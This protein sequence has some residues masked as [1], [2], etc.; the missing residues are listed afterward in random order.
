M[1]TPVVA[2]GLFLLT[3][4]SGVTQVQAQVFFLQGQDGQCSNTITGDLSVSGSVN[5]NAASIGVLT[6]T[7]TATLPNCPSGYTQDTQTTDFVLCTNSRGDEMVQ[8]GDFWIDRYEAS[9]WQHSDCSGMQYGV[10]D[11]NYPATF[12]N[13]GNFDTPVYACSLYS[14]HPSRL[15]TWFQAQAACAASGKHL[16]TNAE[17]QAAAEGTHDPGANDGLSNTLCNTDGAGPRF[18]GLAGGTPGGSDSCISIW[19]AEDMVGNHWEMTAEW[20]IAGQ[21]WQTA[22][23]ESQCESGCTFAGGW[24][25]GY[26]QD[27]TWAWNGEAIAGTG[28]AQGVPAMARR[29][30]SYSGYGTKAG[31][32]AIAVNGGPTNIDFDA[33]V[34][35]CHGR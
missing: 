13:N 18:T 3:M 2:G 17:W 1:A 24:P 30:G 20:F 11:Y 26:G 7:G 28:P 34:R 5:A 25:T 16:C 21:T 6:V 31:V 19:G 12:P 27:A 8:V 29:G 33:G 4:T 23:G 22:A 35:C 10:A 9:I 14:V 32:F 15:T